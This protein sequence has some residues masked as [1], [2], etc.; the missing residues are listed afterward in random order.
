MAGSIR[1]LHKSITLKRRAVNLL[2]RLV[3]LHWIVLNRFGLVS[4][5]D[6]LGS[7]FSRIILHSSTS[8]LRDNIYTFQSGSCIGSPVQSS[9][10]PRIR[11]YV[12]ASESS[13]RRSERGCGRK[14]EHM[15]ITSKNPLI[16]YSLRKTQKIGIAFAISIRSTAHIAC[17]LSFA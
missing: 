3:G 7:V 10:L 4:D 12:P 5:A 11:R 1:L 15:W 6:L 2:F 14:Y 17:F 8:C 9:S 13:K 16:P